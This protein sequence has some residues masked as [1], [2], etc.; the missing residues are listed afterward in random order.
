AQASSLRDLFKPA[1]LRSM[2]FL[3]AM[4]GLWNLWAGTNG[5]FFPY[6]LQTV[7]AQAETT[8][9]AGRAGG[10]LLSM[11][12][13]YCVFMKLSDTVDQRLLFGVSAIMQIGGMALLALFPLT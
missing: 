9:V 8:S 12:S 10:F 3:V 1:H 13:I 7:G 4:Y 6:I 2:A 5:F 11:V